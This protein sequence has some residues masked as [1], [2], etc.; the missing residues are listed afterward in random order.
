MTPPAVAAV[1]ACAA[2][3]LAAWSNH[4][5]LGWLPDDPPRAGRKQ[6]LRPIPLAGIV[7]VPAVT[8]WLVDA[9]AFWALAGIVLTGVVGFIDDRRKEQGRD[10]DWRW[11]A[12]G[13]GFAAA[14]GA[15]AVCWPLPDL[16]TWLL[17]CVFL[18]VLTN[19]TNFLD[20]TD[21]VCASVAAASLLG[22]SSGHGWLGAMGFAAIGFLP[23]NWPQ[24]RLFL[25]DAGTY[26][27]GLATGIAAANAARA[28]FA[29]LWAVSVQLGDFAQ[30]VTARL[31]L[32]V[33]PWIG[34]R[35]H[36]THIAQNLGLPRVLVAPVFVLPA[37]A[38]ACLR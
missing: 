21:G 38:F 34:D 11:K 3:A 2:F 23:W 37:V 12:L 1:V 18:F 35:R 30:V 36:L 8:P 28:D 20:N 14:S 16:L 25:G 27:L 13:L 5:L 6:H 31:V 15:C 24:P 26:A 32:G 10:L 17:V 7:L 22:L 29:N 9:S 19:A 4:N 33:P